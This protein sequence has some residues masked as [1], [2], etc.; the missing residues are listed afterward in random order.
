MSHIA[1]PRCEAVLALNVQGGVVR[2]PIRCRK[3]A[4]EVIHGQ[5]LCRGCGRRR[6]RGEL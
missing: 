3:R 6:S 1:K 4:V 5:L 2:N